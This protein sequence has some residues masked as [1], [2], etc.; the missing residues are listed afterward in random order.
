M[1]LTREQVE[2]LLGELKETAEWKHHI[3]Y[4]LETDAEL[5]ALLKKDEKNA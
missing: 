1:I 5:R 2:Q 4:L 3:T